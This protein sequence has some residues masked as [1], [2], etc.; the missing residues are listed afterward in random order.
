MHMAA[1][2]APAIRPRRGRLGKPPAVAASLSGL[3]GASGVLELP[4]RLFWSAADHTFDLSRRHDALA[5]Y[6]AALSEA[7]TAA[8]LAEFLHGGLLSQLW[9]DL[10][11]PGRI[12]EAWEHAHPA[13]RD[14]A[15]HAVAA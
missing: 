8:D 11:L 1:D 4:C 6:E 2:G 3:R 12:R 13:L 14:R 15:A 5:A 7:R 9:G 10:H